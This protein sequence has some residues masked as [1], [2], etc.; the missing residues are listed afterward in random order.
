MLRGAVL[1]AQRLR[2]APSLDLLRLRGALLVHHRPVLRGEGGLGGEKQRWKETVASLGEQEI[3]LVGDVCVA[4]GAVAYVGPFTSDYRT[5]LAATWR[6]GL[7][8]EGVKHTE[9]ATVGK[10][11]ADAVKLRLHLQHMD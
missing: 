6:A 11:M 10:V 8:A 2:L 4:A 5:D 9:G 7:A 3:N 1:T